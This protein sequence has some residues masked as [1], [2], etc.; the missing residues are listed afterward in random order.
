M[1]YNK[2][3]EET[4]N[5][6]QHPCDA[7]IQPGFYRRVK[8][9]KYNP[10]LEQKGPANKEE[11]ETEIIP[12]TKRVYTKNPFN[13]KSEVIPDTSETPC[14]GLWSTKIGFCFASRAAL[15]AYVTSIGSEL[16]SDNTWYG[17]DLS[18]KDLFKTQ[19]EYLM[20]SLE[21]TG[22]V[23]RSTGQHIIDKRLCM[24]FSSETQSITEIDYNNVRNQRSAYMKHYEDK[25]CAYTGIELKSDPDTSIPKEPT[26]IET[27]VDLLPVAYTAICVPASF[28]FPY[29]SIHKSIVQSWNKL[30]D[31]KFKWELPGMSNGSGGMSTVYDKLSIAMEELGN[32]AQAY[33]QYAIQLAWAE[34]IKVIE[35]ALNIV[36]AGI[37]LL[38]K[39]LPSITIM[40]VKIDIIE[41]CTSPD[42]VQ[43]LKEQLPNTQECIDAIYK[44]INSKYEYAKEYIK[45]TARDI[46]DAITELYDWAWAQL[47][48]AGVALCKLLGDLAEI[49]A[50]PPTIPNPIWLAIRAVKAIFS[51]IPPLDLILSGNFPGFTAS[52]IYQFCMDYV[53]AER[54]KIYQKVKEVEQ[55]ITEL[56]EQSVQLAQELKQKTIYYSQYLAGMWERV[57]EEGKQAYEFAINS[58]KA[59]TEENKKLIAEKDKIKKAFLDSVAD[60]YKMALEQLKK[61]PLFS[62]INTLLGYLGV[63]LD[64][65]MLTVENIRTGLTSTYENFVDGCKS[66]K[67]TCKAIYNQICILAMA[68]VTQWVNKLLYIIGLVINF[69]EMS[70]CA[71]LVKY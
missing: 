52:D 2:I 53:N 44:T 51:Q 12:I 8:W 58:L 61:F 47:Q 25:P 66:L 39:F 9:E 49:W 71:P 28:G 64:D 57:T 36:G 22:G 70:F 26:A 33:S 41:L 19:K 34:F 23:W 3:I 55:Q 16:L 67:E 37:D 32:A 14:S 46:I 7:E 69:P 43:K 45:M 68:K 11:W 59:D 20:Y 35:T 62:T 60:V 6:F 27:L 15:E 10:N 31:F 1:D 38:K 18:K 48:Y 63:S 17:A 4:V 5:D 30:R 13:L 21:N 56:K 54:E 50:M 24:R 40:G 42:G 29:T 65:I